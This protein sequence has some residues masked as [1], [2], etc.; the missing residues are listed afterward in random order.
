MGPIH[1]I[2]RRLAIS[3]LDMEMWLVVTV[4]GTVLATKSVGMGAAAGL[5][6]DLGTTSSGRERQME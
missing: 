1:T 3:N 2:I 5:E 4:M 6:P